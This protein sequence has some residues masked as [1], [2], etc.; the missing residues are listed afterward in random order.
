[1][2]RRPLRAIS[3]ALVVLSLVFVPPAPSA[4]AESVVPEKIDPGLQA[5]MAARP[6]SLLPVI[7]EMQPPTYPFVGPVN[8]T[9]AGEALDLL[10]LYG[11]AVASLALIDS[12]AGFANAAGI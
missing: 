12:A 1:M 2:R 4:R 11:T 8:V 3:C 6:L 9:R 5:L 7:V 10:R